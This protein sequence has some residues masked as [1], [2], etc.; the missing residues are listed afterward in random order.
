MNKAFRES[1]IV[2]PVLILT[3]AIALVAM[4]VNALPVEGL[5]NHELPVANQ[6]DAERRRA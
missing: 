1:L 5:Y 2:F 6:S 4:P 3:L